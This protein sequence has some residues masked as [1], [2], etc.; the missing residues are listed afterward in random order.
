MRKVVIYAQKCKAT[1]NKR[2]K[3]HTKREKREKQKKPFKNSKCFQETM[4]TFWMFVILRRRMSTCFLSLF[5]YRAC[6][7]GA[8]VLELLCVQ[9]T[10]TQFHWTGNKSNILD[11][12][13]FCC[14]VF[15]FFFF[16]WFFMVFFFFYFQLVRYSFF[17]MVWL[18]DL[19]TLYSFSLKSLNGNGSRYRKRR[20]VLPLCLFS[21]FIF[22]YFREV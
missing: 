14:L 7:V 18:L 3:H 6:V 15:L 12:F 5:F 10:G 11:V 2:Q 1:I 9:Y 17:W 13:F 4:K 20:A 21:C 19:L 8:V 22:L 16:V